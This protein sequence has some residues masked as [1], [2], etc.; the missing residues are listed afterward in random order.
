M[1]TS[2]KISIYF[3][4]LTTL[5]GCQNEES[6]SSINATE[7]QELKDILNSSL[8]TPSGSLAR[9]Y[10][11]AGNE[12]SFRNVQ[13]LYYDAAGNKILTVNLN[14]QNDT[15]GASIFFYDLLGRLETKKSF[16]YLDG[17]FSWTGNLKSTFEV[18]GTIENVHLES[19]DNPSPQFRL[20]NVFDTEG[21]LLKTEFSDNERFEYTNEGNLTIRKNH[22]IGETV[23]LEYQY[24]YN[25]E[26][27]LEAKETNL[28]GGGD[29]FQYFYDATGK[30][31]EERE[32]SPQWGYPVLTRKIY[33]YH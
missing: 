23:Y 8:L 2:Y 17:D 14:H 24:R 18:N 29:A 32:N 19:P 28:H 26:G 27:Q 25:S 12:D 1:K 20:R 33:D 31:N 13:N 9:V 11:F 5:L 30:L 6:P 22:I 21:F 3:I 4:L 10:T 7:Q 15:L 16:E